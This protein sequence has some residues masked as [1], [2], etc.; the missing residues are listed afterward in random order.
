MGK[1]VEPKRGEVYLVRFDPTVGAEIKKTRPAV[2]VQ[3]DTANTYSNLTIVA[4]ITSFR[5][6][7]SYPTKVKVLAPEGGL[8]TDS[9][10]LLNQLRTIDKERITKKLGTLNGDTIEKIDKALRI[11][12][13]FMD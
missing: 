2:I 4:A 3:N 1:S 9:I 13:G 6:S 8:D 5:S 7:K 10:V 11:S 12:L